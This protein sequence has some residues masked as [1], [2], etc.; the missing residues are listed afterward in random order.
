MGRL[1]LIC[2]LLISWERLATPVPDGPPSF[3]YRTQN[4]FC[5][6]RHKMWK[7]VDG[8]QLQYQVI[9]FRVR[10]KQYDKEKRSDENEQH[11]LRQLR[12]R[13]TRNI[14]RHTLSAQFLWRLVYRSSTLRHDIRNS[15]L[16]RYNLSKVTESRYQIVCSII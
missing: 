8:H 10:S 6:Q 2:N 1:P 15:A 11:V 7:L 9:G 5:F 12:L 13:I 14:E 16:W 4:D 3:T